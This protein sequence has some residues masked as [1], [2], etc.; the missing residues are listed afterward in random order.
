MLKDLWL[1]LKAR[2]IFSIFPAVN[3]ERKVL[4][5]LESVERDHLKLGKSGVDKALR[6]WWLTTLF[7]ITGPKTRYTNAQ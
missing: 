2:N 3:V 4:I 1:L 6:L 5:E 7:S